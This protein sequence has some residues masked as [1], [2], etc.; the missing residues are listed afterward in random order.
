[1][2]QR[3]V[4]LNEVRRMEEVDW[5]CS[6]P[7]KMRPCT[8]CGKDELSQLSGKDMFSRLVYLCGACLARRLEMDIACCE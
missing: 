4:P 7:R 8:S 2:K 3:Q 5:L 1:M 6:N